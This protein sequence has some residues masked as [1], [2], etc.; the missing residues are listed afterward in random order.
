MSA[1]Q[2]PFSVTATRGDDRIIL[3]V[4]GELDSA[5]AVHLDS[6]IQDVDQSVTGLEVDLTEVSF[7]DSS[8]LRSLVMARQTAEESGRR[9]SISGSSKAVDRLLELTGLETL[10]D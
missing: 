5:T 8:G 6:A 9:F 2:A 10:R 3:T 7:I 4:T 1:E